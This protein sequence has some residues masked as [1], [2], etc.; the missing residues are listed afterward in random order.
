M[1]FGQKYGEVI[2]QR[3][4]TMTFGPFIGSTM[5]AYINDIVVK[6]KGKWCHMRD[7]PEVFEINKHKVRL[8]SAKG[9]LKV[10]SGKFLG[11]LVN[12]Q[13]IEENLE[14][15]MAINDLESSRTAMKVHKLTRMAATLNHF[16]SKPFDKCYPFFQ[17]LRKTLRI[18]GKMSAISRSNSSRSI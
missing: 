2:Y 10:S 5:N 17:L 15:I 11:H 4:I 18:L 9:M 14:H 3:M 8:N 1:P 6:S 12:Q 7:L 16:I 13:G